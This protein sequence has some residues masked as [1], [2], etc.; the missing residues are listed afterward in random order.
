MRSR[1]A[2]TG[3]GGARAQQG[4]IAGSER[5]DLTYTARN[6]NDAAATV[7]IEHHPRPG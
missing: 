2:T 5:R 7:V 6:D 3:E 4:V 1:I